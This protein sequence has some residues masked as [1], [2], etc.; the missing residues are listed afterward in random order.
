MHISSAASNYAAQLQSSTARKLDAE[1]RVEGN[2][3]DGDNDADD[4]AVAVQGT[5]QSSVEGS[6][7]GRF[8]NVVA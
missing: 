5:T 2:K 4:K 3:P 1:S 7:I 8:L 6:N